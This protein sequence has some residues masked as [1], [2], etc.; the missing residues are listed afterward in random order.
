MF[1][2]L[3]DENIQPQEIDIR[4]IPDIEISASLRQKLQ[5][6][7]EKEE[8]NTVVV[9]GKT[10]I[11]KTDRNY[12]FFS[13]QWLYLAVI[14]KK[15]AKALITYGDFFDQTI[16]GNQEL[17][18]ILAKK[19]YGN[20]KL[21]DV[22][23]D[24]IAREQFIKFVEP[25]ASYRPGKALLNGDRTR[26]TKDIFG[27]CILKKIPVPDA[28]SAYLGNLVY[29][30]AKRPELYDELERE[31]KLQVGNQN[32]AKRLPTIT[33][34]CA[35][36]IIDC[37][38]DMDAFKSIEHLFEINDKNIKVDISKT[39]GLLPN[40][41]FLRYLFA[42][43]NSD[44]Y[45]GE[46]EKPRVFN[47]REYM[48]SSGGEEI[49]CR[50]TT[51][52]VDSELKDGGQ[53]NFLKA[54]IAI[55]NKYYNDRIGIKSEL[56]ERY[57]YIMKDKFKLKELPEVFHTAFA[58]RYVTSLL[59]K[60]FVVL[61]GNSGT[62]KTIISK[63]FAEY[64]EWISDEGKKNWLIVPVGA[65]WTDNSRILGFYNP[66][67]N[68]GTGKY[69]STN[70]VHLIEEANKHSDIPYFL[71]LDEMNLSHVERYFSDFLSH[72]ETPDT[73]FILDGY[74]G[75]EQHLGELE[76]PDNLFVVGTVNIDETT[77]M[78]SPKVLDRANV[79]EFKPEK[80][81]VLKL[82]SGQVNTSKV[83]PAYDGTAEAFL[84][85]SKEIRAGK[86]NIDES[87]NSFYG[88]NMDATQETN[89]NYVEKVFSE[90]Y[91]IVEKSDFEF[92]FRTV[93]EIKQYIS[94]AYELS[95]GDNM[96]LNSVLDEQLLQKIM[97][98]I[99]GNKKEIGELLE[100]LGQLCQKYRFVLSEK[101]IEQMKGKL[102]KV[103]YASFI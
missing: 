71:I 46:F 36:A 45:S 59:A 53:G 14:C 52:W 24:E 4:H 43:P 76:Y 83:R 87:G 97:P 40:G 29:Y 80:E 13:N 64:M 22:L 54:L 89:M 95:D 101:K 23:P 85:L 51:E 67:A 78:F 11:V 86:L 96:N 98:K 102:V 61:T 72:M 62:G 2:D 26:T 103:Q 60:P 20:A 82:F 35:K 79:I 99:H 48:I 41:N 1:C 88:D 39:E 16:R 47:Q 19:D 77:Y 93:K 100:S 50:L 91:E 32:G 31:I 44:L 3:L 9:S 15:Y 90:I 27:S 5:K 74:T 25:D 34:D 21:I 84:K 70:I 92:A 57:L 68:D 94:S 73:N 18:N 75:E 58:R 56:G 30:L 17:I 66:I 38:Y 49:V 6:A 55:V 42:R 28:S 12:V 81:D 37:I 7:L 33:K 69:E 63:Q 10:A 8:E 65:D